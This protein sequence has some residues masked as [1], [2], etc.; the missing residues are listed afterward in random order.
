M[1]L[2]QPQGDARDGPHV[3]RDPLALAA[4]AAGGGLEQGAVPVDQ[5]HRQAVEL[6]LQ[7]VLHRKALAEALPQ[8]LVEPAQ[9]RFLLVGVEGQHGSRVLDRRKGVERLP[10]DPLGRGVVRDQI[11]E[12]LLQVLQLVEEAVVVRVGDIRTVFDVIEIVVVADLGSQLG[13]PFSGLGWI[14]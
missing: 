7:D 6:G 1:A 10:G 8:P 9:S 4:V 3:R 2:A 5:L 14:P 11:G 13:D 12:L